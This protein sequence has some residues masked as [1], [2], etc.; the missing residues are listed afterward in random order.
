MNPSIGAPIDEGRARLNAAVN[1]VYQRMT[2]AF[3]Q[4]DLDLLETVY[5]TDCIYLPRDREADAAL[6]RGAFWPMFVELFEQK[7]RNGEWIEFTFRVIRRTILDGAVHDVGYYRRIDIGPDGNRPPGHGKFSTLSMPM[8][9]GN[10]CFTYDGDVPATALA[11]EAAV[12]VPGAV[13]D[14]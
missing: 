13:F 5:A 2:T 11:Y 6:G 1:A 14:R 4:L 3:A 9:N 7:R 8:P 12:P 10:W